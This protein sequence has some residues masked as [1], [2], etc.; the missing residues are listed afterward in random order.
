MEEY[1]YSVV[2]DEKKS[3]DDVVMVINDWYD[4]SDTCNYVLPVS[5]T[6]DLPYTVVKKENVD[7]KDK[8]Y[9]VSYVLWH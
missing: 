1:V 8:Y 2:A 7:D 4:G 9:D 5:E 3:D 6:P